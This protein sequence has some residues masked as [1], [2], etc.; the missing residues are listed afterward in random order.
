VI[1]DIKNQQFNFNVIEIFD[2]ILYKVPL[3]GT[4][5]HEIFEITHRRIKIESQRHLLHY[6]TRSFFQICVIII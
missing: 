4:N 6:Q 3:S 1:Y 2:C 5:V